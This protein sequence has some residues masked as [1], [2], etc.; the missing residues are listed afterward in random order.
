MQTDETHI[1]DHTLWHR[2]AGDLLA[3]ARAVE[4]EARRGEL[5]DRVHELRAFI[6]AT[7]A[8]TPAGLATQI[9]LA[10]EADEAGSMLGELELAALRSAHEALAARDDDGALMALWR[11]YLDAWHEADASDGEAEAAMDRIMA[12]ETQVARMPAHGAAGALV[13]LRLALFQRD[14]DAAMRLFVR[15]ELSAAWLDP[16]T[17]LAIEALA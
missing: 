2:Q 4:D 9:S 1:S 8:E 17:R 13:H 16:H 11:S 10:I 15:R 5:H 14:P 6:A 7:P 3:Q 12:L